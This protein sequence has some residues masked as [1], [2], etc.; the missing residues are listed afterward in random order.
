M[1]N[2]TSVEET[3][4]FNNYHTFYKNKKNNI[5]ILIYK[6]ILLSVLVISC[7]SVLLFIKDTFFAV[8]MFKDWNAKSFL[9]FDS[10]ENI[11]KNI[12]ILV[13]FVL[14]V[15]VFFY[16]ITKN[17][18]NLYFQ[19][20][21][22]K[23]YWPWFS[24]YLTLSIISIVLLFTYFEPNPTKNVYLFLILMPLFGLNL[25]YSSYTFNLKRKTDPNSKNNLASLIITNSSQ[26]LLLVIVLILAFSWTLAAD[27]KAA[28]TEML[29]KNNAFFNF[30]KDLLVVKKTK[31]WF[32][33][34]AF[35]L[36]VLS[37][38][39]GINADKI[40]F[41]VFKTKK[42]EY[43]GSS[44]VISLAIL[45]T[46]I[47]WLIRICFVKFDELSVL[48]SKF[49]NNIFLIEI[50]FVA[51]I[52]TCYML[53][54]FLNKLKTNSYIINT[55][56]VSFFE[57]LLWISLFITTLLSKHNTLVN[58]INL[59]FVTIGSIVIMIAYLQKTTEFNFG[60]TLLIKLSLSIISLTSLIFGINQILLSQNNLTFL[61]ID[62]NLEITQIF[63][64]ITTIVWTIFLLST[65]IWLVIV[66]NKI[67]FFKAKKLET[68]K[69]IEHEK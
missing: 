17:Y 7:L 44:I 18:M 64:L 60:I 23:K 52:V 53:F 29:L 43:F 12:L 20:E 36:V 35:S 51:I 21:K 8:K 34:F 49:Q 10:I 11:Q 47:L 66:A 58:L 14:L 24:L 33:I 38:L 37:L 1:K 50:L 56:A 5:D 68:K 67:S 6:I 32:I 28:S 2:Q 61:T 19:K 15:F 3:K 13:R 39:F 41:L 26:F 48:G 45:S 9:K 22:I 65:I 46:F 25:I 40:W 55:I 4:I 27:S 16:T 62:S 42:D 31:S 57:T 30:W 69:G 63:L 59:L 54:Q